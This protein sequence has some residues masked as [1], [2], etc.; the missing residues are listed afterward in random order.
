MYDNVVHN[1]V[2]LIYCSDES[3][4]TAEIILILGFICSN[5][6]RQQSYEDIGNK[7]KVIV[8]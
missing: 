4:F 7:D 5:F 8:V 2:T 1:R 3:L 6:H